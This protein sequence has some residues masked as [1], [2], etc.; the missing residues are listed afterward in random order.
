M[1]LVMPFGRFDD[2]LGIASLPQREPRQLPHGNRVSRRREKARGTYSMT[3]EMFR[4]GFLLANSARRA[5][6]VHEDGATPR[7]GATC[8]HELGS[9]RT[10]HH[11]HHLII[12]SSCQQ[13]TCLVCCTRI[14]AMSQATT[15]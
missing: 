15:K 11:H 8:F 12:L 3:I 9:F 4:V 10:Y 14:K 13:V 2:V 7:F 5:W 1:A 6:G